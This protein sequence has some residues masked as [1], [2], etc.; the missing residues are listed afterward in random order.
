MKKTGLFETGFEWL[1]KRSTLFSTYEKFFLFGFGLLDL[2]DSKKENRLLV[3]I[4]GITH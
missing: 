4:F 2:K 3:L 1:E